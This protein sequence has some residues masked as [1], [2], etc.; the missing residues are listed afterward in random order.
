MD[1]NGKNSNNSSIVEF[2][3]IEKSL[4][5]QFYSSDQLRNEINSLITSNR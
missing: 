3:E 5:E 2:R 1:Q 4:M